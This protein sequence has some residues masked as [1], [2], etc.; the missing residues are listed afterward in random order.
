MWRG[1]ENNCVGMKGKFLVFVV[2][3][4]GSDVV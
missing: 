3:N 4:D 2:D 1:V